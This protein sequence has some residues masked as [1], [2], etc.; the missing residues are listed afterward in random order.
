MKKEIILLSTLCL[1]FFTCQLFAWESN[2]RE[3]FGQQEYIGN[4]DGFEYDGDV[5]KVIHI[6]LSQTG[7]RV[8]LPLA[9]DAEYLYK[10]NNYAPFNPE[11][12]IFLATV[13]AIVVG[14]KVVQI[15]VLEVPS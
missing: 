4:F 3:V 12:L 11:N 6:K 1:I 14:E 8:S 5:K 9:D 15:I 7:Y 10:Q 13:K 2:N